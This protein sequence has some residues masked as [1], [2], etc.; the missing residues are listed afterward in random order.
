MQ[1]VKIWCRGLSLIGQVPYIEG[2]IA[3]SS[4]GVAALED[5]VQ[6]VARSPRR[7]PA[8]SRQSSYR[9]PDRGHLYLTIKGVRYPLEFCLRMS[10][11]TS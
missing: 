1:Q 4:A 5:A 7:P 9:E 8:E 11:V 10:L 6:G 3:L 2:S